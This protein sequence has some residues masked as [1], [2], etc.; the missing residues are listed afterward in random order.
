MGDFKVIL[1]VGI[2]YRFGRVD[3]IFKY[4][5]IGEYSKDEYFEVNIDY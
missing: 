2:C 4:F 3:V 1:K 5:G